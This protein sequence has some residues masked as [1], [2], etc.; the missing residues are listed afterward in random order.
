MNALVDTVRPVY[1]RVRP[2]L[3]RR[4][5]RKQGVL[6]NGRRLFDLTGD[7][8]NWKQP[9]ADAIRAHTAEGDRTVHVGGG[10]GITPV[11]S[12]EFGPV[13]VF[14]G[15]RKYALGCRETARLNDAA[16]RISVHHAV[17]EAAN[18]LW[19]DHGGA[20]TLSAADLP[21]CDVLVLD[22]EGAEGDI[23]PA[24]DDPLPGVAIVECGGGPHHPLEE[25]R[26]LLTA[27]GF[28]IVS[29]EPQADQY[30]LVAKNEEVLHT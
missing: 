29:F 2:Y 12:A 28:E 15:A 3:P 25:T 8:P 18:D 22:C 21:E 19:G 5:A 9:L 10:W 20:I 6:F 11:I 13:A 16:D 30:I 14:E 24:L 7:Q 4:T 23:I 27:A 26:D 17:V 1:N